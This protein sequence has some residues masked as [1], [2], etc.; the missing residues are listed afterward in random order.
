[1]SSGR[2]QAIALL[3]SDAKPSAIFCGNDVLAMGV[4]SILHEQGIDVPGTVSVTGYDDIEFAGVVT[5]ALTTVT[6]PMRAMG[7]VAA[8][9]LNQRI[10]QPDEPAH[11]VT[12][13]GELIV[14]GFTTV[15]S[16]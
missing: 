7:A 5:P 4:L 10:D 1:M 12:L 14:R 16:E 6:Q 15:A 2:E 11:S 13:K 8:R 3:S 9:L